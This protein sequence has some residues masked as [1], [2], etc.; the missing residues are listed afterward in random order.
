[1]N[2][3]PGKTTFQGSI[4]YI[5]GVSEK[6]KNVLQEVGVSVGMKPMS[7]LRALLVRKRPAP[8]EQLGV[9]YS[10]P[11]SQCNWKYVGESGRT[12]EERKKEHARAIRTLDVTRS[13]VAQHAHEAD[14]RVELEK[15]KLIDKELNWRKRVIKEALWSKQLSSSNRTK[16]SL[17]DGWRF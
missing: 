3:V 7:T 6:I 16:F 10:I 2:A 15:M 17:S 14:H 1:M 5:P 9:V 13:E 11:G 12:L 8:P 4:P